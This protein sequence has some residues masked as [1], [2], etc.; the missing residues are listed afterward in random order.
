V[1]KKQV[2]VFAI[3]ILLLAGALR[4]W[5]LPRPPA[6]PYYDEAANGILASSIANDGYRP[7][8]IPS[9]TGKEVL[10]F[11]PAAGLIKLLGDGLLAL[12]LTSAIFGTLTVA[13][14]L[15]CVYEL[16]A[17]EQKKS[18][19]ALLAAGLLGASFWHLGLSRIG[20]RAVSQPLLQAL[21]LAMLW[22]GLRQASWKSLLV[23]G[24]LCGLAA[25][26]YL[27]ARLFPVPLALALLA[28][29]LADR[30]NWR[31]RLAQIGVFGVAA[32]VV[33]TPLGLYF[34]R[35]LERFSVRIEQVA[36]QGPTLTL[37]EAFRQALGIFYVAGDPLARLNIPYQPLF[38]PL[39]AA[40]FLFGLGLTVYHL[41]KKSEPLARARSVLL[42]C[43]IP[44]M[45]LPT[46]LTVADII[47]HYLRAA[48]MLPLIY[49]FPAL[50]L[51]WLVE[52]VICWRPGWSV[53][54]PGLALVV[55]LT[56]TAYATTRDY[57]GDLAKRQDHY[58]ISDGDLA[59]MAEWLNA[60]DLTDTTVYVASKHYRHPTLA[61]LADDYS[62]FKWLT[63]GNTVVAPAAG[64]AIILFPRS[65]DHSWANRSLPPAT[66]LGIPAAPDGDPAFEVYGMESDTPLDVFPLVDTY[67]DPVNFSNV[68]QL[69]EYEI[70]GNPGFDATLDA[71]LSWQV[72][73]PAPSGDYHV[74]AHLVDSWGTQWAEILPFQYPSAMWTPGERFLDRLHLDL[75]PGIPPGSYY[76]LEVG[77]YSPQADHN[78]SA[79]GPDGR[80]AGTVARIPITLKRAAIPKRPSD[81]RRMLNIEMIPDLMLLGVNLDTQTARTREPIFL[82]LYWQATAHSLGSGYIRLFL[83]DHLLYEGF[84]VHSMYSTMSWQKDEYVVDRYNPRVPLDMPAGQWPLVL[85]VELAPVDGDTRSAELGTVIVQVPERSFELPQMQETLNKSLGEAVELL[86]YDVVGLDSANVGI[87]LY[88]RAL[89]EMETDYTVFVHLL[90]ANNSML[91]QV[92]AMPHSGRYPTSIWAAG[93]VVVDEYRILLPAGAGGSYTLRVGMYRPST[94][95][96][97]G[98]PLLIGPLEP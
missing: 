92:D 97:L 24:I 60:A 49:L 23:G 15:W 1:N 80:F 3:L 10:F 86:G 68:I 53:C 50:T 94:G 41:F 46:A 36:V 85:Q 70:Q 12:R 56:P 81:I 34:L 20:L 33:L 79:V 72:L 57:F 9:Y 22:R 51:A 47:P 27:A 75:P 82:N 29:L 43:W 25:Y 77:L 40:A 14:T 4:V 64:K 39:L 95:E 48:G 32:A 54:T 35:N 7:I 71:V 18:I 11:Y 62:Q 61:F 84:S 31:P 44:I 38:G 30:A 96:Q 28:L 74:F 5:A 2:S 45:I 59:D 90:D 69:N 63:G 6:G 67:P 87:T 66:F 78:L 52:R 19:L 88:W 93:E 91:G 26:T 13:A 76:Q 37:S 65:V 21:T 58:E 16:F 8:F 83:G 55:V 98:E 42:L 73:N 17:Q 89:E